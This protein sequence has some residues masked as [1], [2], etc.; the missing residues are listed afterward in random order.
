MAWPL[1]R[2]ARRAAIA[3]GSTPTR[4]LLR[5][6]LIPPHLL[7]WC[8]TCSP[9]LALSPHW[10]AFS[11]SSPPHVRPHLPLEDNLQNPL[12]SA[13]SHSFLD[14]SDFED[15]PGGFTCSDVG[16]EI[17][18][19]LQLVS[20]ARGEC[21]SKEEAMS[22]LRDSEIELNGDM[23]SSAIWE[24][25]GDWKSAI[26][27]FHW[28]E[29]CLSSCARAW[30]LMIWVLA[31]N[32]KFN[33]AWL[34]VRQ[35]YRLKILS[36]RPFTILMERYAA[37][38]QPN[39]AIKTFDVMEMFKI[40][41]NSSTFYSLLRALCKHKNVEDAEQLLLSRRKFFPLETEG[42]NIILDGW[43]NII[44]DVVEAKRLWREMS[45]C[46][47]SPDGTSYAN[48]ICCFSNVGNLFDSTRLY[49]EMKKRGFVPGISVYNALIYVLTR[50]NCVKEA[51]KL[52]DRIE[53]AGLRADE[54]TY[55]SIIY[56]LCEAH[57]VQEALDMLEDMIKKGLTP[58]IETY[59]AF[60]KIE[61]IDGTLNLIKRMNDDGCG[62]NR[63]T[64]LLI[65]EKFFKLDQAGNALRIWKEMRTYNICPH[66]THYAALIQGLA[67]C[68]WIPKALEFYN[69][70]KS[71][72]F[73]DSNVE[74]LIR[75]I[76]TRNKNS[77][78]WGRK[79]RY[80][81]HHLKVS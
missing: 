72:G 66:Y 75:D 64:F 62:P 37:A 39:D 23:L 56:P 14:T 69:E 68:G 38:N 73:H 49:D 13:G 55:K 51:K 16:P 18:D 79:E 4:I 35:M 60:A 36:Q 52:F 67:S 27:A 70:M 41:A 44:I 33:I 81:G 47:I 9:P 2:L 46:C 24:L 54:D 48:M 29:E 21:S 57:K 15:A 31:R 32:G 25:R 76:S 61:D 43:C 74:R 34:L 40:T 30:H 11:S 71:R 77:K 17:P 28:G 50:E 12:L 3:G 8:S 5:R 19:V 80:K 65:L 22:L 1:L 20:R 6:P 59:H 45:N 42:F 63:Y 26:L 10:C 7:S 78:H 58:T 53:D